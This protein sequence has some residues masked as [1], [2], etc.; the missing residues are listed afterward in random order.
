MKF[1]ISKTEAIDID[2]EDDYKMAC[3]LYNFKEG[4]K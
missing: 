1:I 4:K 3:G 2:D